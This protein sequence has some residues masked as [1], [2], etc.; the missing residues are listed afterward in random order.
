MALGRSALAVT[1]TLALAGTPLPIAA[2]DATHAA[3]TAPRTR[4][5]VS[6]PTVLLNERVA[7]PGVYAVRVAIASRPSH[8]DRV[9]IAIGSLTRHATTDRAGRAVVTARVAVRTHT[10]SI[11]ASARRARP[12]LS[13]TVQR[14]RSIR[15]PTKPPTGKTRPSGPRTSTPSAGSLDATSAPPTIPTGATT[16]S[17]GATG[18]TGTTG[19]TG[20][21][22]ATGST[23]AVGSA[24]PPG[25]A[26]SWHQ[27]F[28]DEF[29]SP[30]LDA[31][32]WSS[33]WQGGS[34]P[35]NSSELQCYDPAQ[36]A[37]TN[38]ELDLN[39]IAKPETCGGQTRPYA[40]AMI[41][42][43]GKYNYTYGYLEARVWV[44]GTTAITDWPAVWTDGQSWPQDGELDI[45]EGLSGQ[46]CWHFHDPQGGPGGCSSAT[47]TGGW[48][49][50]GADWEAGT[51]TY[52]YDG[53]PADTITTGITNSP[54]Y[55]I[56]NL[57]ADTAN[58]GPLQAPATM[59]VDY[60]HLWQH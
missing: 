30:T 56:L 28:A 13:V 52:Y 26:A 22:S 7:S 49:T 8:A 3:L 5:A 38:G 37:L 51:V 4:D 12:T 40:S 32:K 39:L 60:I 6:P 35:V 36:I 45:M 34:T 9:L 2:A 47:Y 33:G 15:R 44:S 57:A 24:G 19:A 50:Y 42:T 58:S 55:I 1:A 48:H 16:A 27:V 59:R 25:S 31:S 46:A 14:L 41:N 10:L 54:M 23:G 43:E 53:T 17:S 29:N 20:S 11:R 18:S 21:T